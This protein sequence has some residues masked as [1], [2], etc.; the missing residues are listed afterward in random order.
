MLFPHDLIEI[1][2]GRINPFA[3][4]IVERIEHIIED[5][6]AQMA[7]AYLINI[8]KAHYKADPDGIRVLY[9]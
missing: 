7:H 2:P 8:R 1:Q 3:P 5:L 4:Y 9:A 6:D